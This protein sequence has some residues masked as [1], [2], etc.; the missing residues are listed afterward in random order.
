MKQH[1]Y[2]ITG[3]FVIVLCVVTMS[4]V[5]MILKLTTNTEKIKDT[6]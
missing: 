4:L 2:S 5:L 6:M 1:H 3:T